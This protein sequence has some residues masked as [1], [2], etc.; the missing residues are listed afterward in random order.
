M[1]SK[2]K[3]IAAAALAAVFVQPVAADNVKVGII[4]TLS[5]PNASLGQ[6]MDQA[7][8][9]YNKLH[10]RDIAPHTVEIVL[11]DDTG[12]APDVAR[13]IAQELITRDRVNILGGVVFTP[14][15]HAIAPL[16]TEA[17]MPLVIM[18]AG[19]SVTTT[20]SPYFARVSFTLWQ[21]SFPMGQWAHQAGIRSV[22]TAVT[23]YGPGHDAEAAFTKAFTE[24]GGKIAGS[25]RM[26]LANPDFVPFIQRAKDA[27]PEAVFTFVPAGRQATAFMK[28]FGERGMREAN[29]RLIGP[30]DIVTD[31]ELPNMGDVPLG[32]V[33]MHHYSSVHDSPTNR[34]FQA[35]WKKE[36][37]PNAVPGFM[38]VGAWDGMAA[39][40]HV[41]KQQN[42]KLDGDRTMA[43]LKGWKHESPR[44]PIMIDP[45]TRDIVQNEYIRRVEKLGNALANIEIGTIPQVKDPWKVF[46]PPK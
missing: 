23:D 32:V 46:N 41:I 18:N 5:G 16:A 37:G 20:L 30:G 24:A 14:N 35:A 26:P 33:T 4:T 9:L 13:R 36:Y 21:S 11:R 19:T 44:G 39:I 8:K 17:K 40:Y 15:A 7:I 38:A 27:N 42:G 6:Q 12:P 3:I 2:L 25:V 34:E 1:T 22:F 43:L 29:I 31:E 28:A 45:D 10:A